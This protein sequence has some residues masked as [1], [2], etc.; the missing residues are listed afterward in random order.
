MVLLLFVIIIYIIICLTMTVVCVFMNNSLAGPGC[1]MAPLI[2]WLKYHSVEASKETTCVPKERGGKVHNHGFKYR[3][4]E[5]QE[6]VQTKEQKG[7]H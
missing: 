3:D 1:K 7:I 2:E 6:E 4:S 5:N